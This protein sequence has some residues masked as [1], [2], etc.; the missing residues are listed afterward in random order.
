MWLVRAATNDYFLYWLISMIIS[1]LWLFYVQTKL[2]YSNCLFCPANRQ[3][4]IYSDNLA[5]MH[6]FIK[7]VFGYVSFDWGEV[8]PL[9]LF[10]CFAF[11]C[12][13]IHFIG[14]D[15]YT[16]SQNIWN[17]VGWCDEQGEYKTVCSCLTHFPIMCCL[18]FASV[19]FIIY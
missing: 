7:I 4:Q 5:F 16:Y 8:S 15:F 1:I 11:L 13:Q 18:I 6:L 14:S 19:R 10:V 9:H 12:F 2:K 17:V 3:T